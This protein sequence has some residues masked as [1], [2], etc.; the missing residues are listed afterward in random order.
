MHAAGHELMLL[1]LQVRLYFP[2]GA[3]NSPADPYAGILRAVVK[4]STDLYAGESSVTFLDS[5]GDVSLPPANLGLPPLNLV[6]SDKPC[7]PSDMPWNAAYVVGERW[8]YMTHGRADSTLGMRSQCYSLRWSCNLQV[9]NTARTGG[10]SQQQS[11]NLADGQWHMVTLTTHPEGGKGFQ[12]Y[13]DGSLAG[14]MIP[15]IQYT[16]ISLLLNYPPA[17]VHHGLS[18]HCNLSF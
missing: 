7:P 8:Q 5:N 6:A 9:S 18:Q 14:Q 10:A 1:A 17:G 4:D 11:A 13:V 12:L 3:T 15:G 2:G 16:G